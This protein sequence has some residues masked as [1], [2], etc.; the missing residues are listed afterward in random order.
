MYVI[1]YFQLN[2]Y[3]FWL[4][5]ILLDLRAKLAPTSWSHLQVG[6]VY[7]KLHTARCLQE[8]ATIETN[9]EMQSWYQVAA[10]YLTLGLILT[11]VAYFFWT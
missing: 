11:P 1:I 2:I 9:T 8:A 6:P 7:V 10:S 5:L 4:K 3:F